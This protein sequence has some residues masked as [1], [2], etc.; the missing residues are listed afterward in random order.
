VSHW[1]STVDSQTPDSYGRTNV[2]Y[3]SA[4]YCPKATLEQWDLSPACSSIQ[5]GFT[6]Y[7]VWYA[8]KTDALGFAGYNAAQQQIV[9]AFK[10]TDPSHLRDW[11]D[12]LE[13]CFS[14]NTTCTISDNLAFKGSSGFCNYYL[15]LKNEGLFGNVTQLINQFPNYEIL[16]V[17]HSLGGAA[18]VIH[19]LDLLYDF[20][21]T[22]R[23][24]LITFGEPRV[25][26]YSVSQLFASVGSDVLIYRFIHDRDIVPHLPPC[27]DVNNQCE[28]SAECPYHEPREVWYQNDMAPGEPYTV[29]SPTIGEDFTCSDQDLD[30]SVDDHLVYFG[31]NVGEGC[32]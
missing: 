10:G 12:D 32:C 25:G 8:A 28:T 5:N 29:C 20:K 7:G 4:A 3:A 15:S 30:Y 24:N 1:I 14:F 21:P 11:I 16:V 19:A 22:Q 23:I 17:G 6:V 18:A 9:V 26:D 13:G 31:L 2:P 27:C